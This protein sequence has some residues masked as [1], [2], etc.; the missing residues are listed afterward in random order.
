VTGSDP[1]GKSC[2]PDHPFGMMD[3]AVVAMQPFFDSCAT[4]EI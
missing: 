1:E 3:D 4:M 2:P